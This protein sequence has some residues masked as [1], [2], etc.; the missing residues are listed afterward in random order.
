[1]IK[2]RIN[3]KLAKGKRMSGIF[4]RL[5][6]RPLHKIKDKNLLMV[7]VQKTLLKKRYKCTF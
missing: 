6:G 5:L 7:D 4:G 2:T 3:G 1:M